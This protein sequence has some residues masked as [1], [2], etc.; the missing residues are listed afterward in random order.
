M[1]RFLLLLPLLFFTLL[2]LPVRG[3][4][5]SLPSDADSFALEEIIVQF[6]PLVPQAAIDRITQGAG[7]QIKETLF[8]PRTFVLRVPKG[9]E[10]NL[11][12]TLSQNPLVSYAEPKL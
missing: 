8:L 4:F 11:A 7:A 3:V 1:R 5:G 2:A 12:K 10:E 6:R 9:L